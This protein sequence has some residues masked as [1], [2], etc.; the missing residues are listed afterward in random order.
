M[1]GSMPKMRLVHTPKESAAQ[2]ICHVF[3]HAGKAVLLPASR[4]QGA[5][6]DKST[7]AVSSGIWR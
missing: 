5:I 6:A 2:Y 1:D 4:H 3:R 7:R